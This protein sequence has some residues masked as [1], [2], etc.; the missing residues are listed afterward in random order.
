MEFTAN[1]AT[2]TQLLVTQ[3]ADLV[4]VGQGLQS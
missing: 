4:C 2:D 3:E 1:E